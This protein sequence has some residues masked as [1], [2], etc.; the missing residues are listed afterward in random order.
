MHNW[1]QNTDDWTNLTASDTQ[2]VKVNDLTVLSDL[3]PYERK[4]LMLYFMQPAELNRTFFLLSDCNKQSSH[5]RCTYAQHSATGW[6][7]SEDSENSGVWRQLGK[8]LLTSSEKMHC[9]VFYLSDCISP[10]RSS[11]ESH[12][13]ELTFKQLPALECLQSSMGLLLD[14]TLP[15]A[16]SQVWCYLEECYPHSKEKSAC[17]LPQVFFLPVSS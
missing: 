17:L 13:R 4:F 7:A 8:T 3:I 15:C 11:V 9:F 16:G 12:H 6:A 10:E 1:V 14:S 5:K 2:K